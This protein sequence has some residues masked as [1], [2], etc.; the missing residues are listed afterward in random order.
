MF[1]T[2]T[3]IESD[4]LFFLFLNYKKSNSE[5]ITLLCQTRR[6]CKAR[7]C[8]LPL[9][10]TEIIQFSP[11]CCSFC[12]PPLPG[13]DK[14][15]PTWPLSLEPT[16]SLRAARLP[17]LFAA[18]FLVV[19]HFASQQDT[20]PR[21]PLVI[22]LHAQPALSSLICSVSPP[23]VCPLLL[24]FIPLSH[25]TSFLP[26]IFALLKALL[27]HIYLFFVVSCL[28]THLQP[29]SHTHTFLL[30]HSSF[31]F[32]SSLPLSLSLRPASMCSGAF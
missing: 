29:P 16:A 28:H 23:L 15:L 1:V 2:K 25:H 6:I 17:P 12:G 10:E 13:L 14:T 31:F 9:L 7:A 26:L 21:K 24:S 19:L 5:T 4:L 18:V 11:E 30:P 20:K 27:F 8:A 3:T 22:S 32:S